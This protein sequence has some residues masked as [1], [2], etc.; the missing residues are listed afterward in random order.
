MLWTPTLA[1]GKGAGRVAGTVG[2]TTGGIKKTVG[3]RRGLWDSHRQQVLEMAVGMGEPRK[4]GAAMM[5][6]YGGTTAGS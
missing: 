4:R 1:V 2:G 6:G 5:A 3:C